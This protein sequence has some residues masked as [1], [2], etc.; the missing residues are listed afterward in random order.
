VFSFQSTKYQPVTDILNP[1]EIGVKASNTIVNIFRGDQD[2]RFIA[3]VERIMGFEK[4]K[5]H[6]GILE[7]I[8]ISDYNP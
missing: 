4:I 7:F 1:L 5:V 6:L 2:D 3:E 8:P